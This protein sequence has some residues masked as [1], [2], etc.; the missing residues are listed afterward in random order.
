MEVHTPRMQVGSRSESRQRVQALGLI[1]R[2]NGEGHERRGKGHRRGA[3]VLSGTVM[4]SVHDG[5]SSV[6]NPDEIITAL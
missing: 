2:V 6:C 1:F 3:S 4:A 5:Y